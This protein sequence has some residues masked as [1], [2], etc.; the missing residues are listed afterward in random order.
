MSVFAS[1]RVRARARESESVKKETHKKKEIR[2]ERK[3]N[4]FIKLFF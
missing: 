2:K 4:C 1:E 3:D